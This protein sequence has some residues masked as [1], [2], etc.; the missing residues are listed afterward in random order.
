MTEQG[1][2]LFGDTRIDYRVLRSRRRRK[3]IE[4]TL[5]HQEGVLVAAPVHT[6]HQTIANVVQKRAAWIIRRA[7]SQTL[8]PAPKQLVSGESLPYLGRQVRLFVEPAAVR[9]V[10]VSFAHWS[11]GVTVPSDLT[12]EERRLAMARALERWYKQR[13][14]I[15]LA[16]RVGHWASQLGYEPPQVLIR[17]QRQRWGSCGPDGVLRFNWRAMQVEPTLIDYV[18]VHELV[19]LLVRN[20]GADF[21]MRVAGAL[22]DYRLRRQRLKEAGAHLVL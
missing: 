16:D 15:W 7:S 6:D 10:R 14:M 12:G 4:I 11:F 22:P 9:R 19:H 3:T 13:A 5:D 2:I 8:Q 1:F 18:V 17:S 20:H 21:W